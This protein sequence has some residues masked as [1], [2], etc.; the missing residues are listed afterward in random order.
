MNTKQL[1]LII[2][3]I[4]SVLFGFSQNVISFKNNNG[5]Y[6]FKD[7]FGNII[8]PPKYDYV[9]KE[10]EQKFTIVFNGE[11]KEKYPHKGKYGFVNSEGIETIKPKYDYVDREYEEEFTIVF[12]GEVKDGYPYKGKYGFVNSD[13]IE[14]IKPKYDYILFEFGLLIPVYVYRVDE[15]GADDK[16]KIGFINRN[17]KEIVGLK[18][19]YVASVNESLYIV[20]TGKTYCDGEGT[21]VPVKGKYNIINEKGV[22]IIEPLDDIIWFSNELFKTFIG[23]TYNG[24]PQKGKYGLINNNGQKIKIKDYDYIGELSDS[25]ARVF[26]GEVNEEGIPTVGKWGY[27][28]NEGNEIISLKYDKA[29]SFKNGKA[30]VKLNGED[31]YINTKGERIAE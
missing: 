18:Y 25:L 28:D 19:N 16:S 22:K 29:E 13:G 3:L 6:G 14:I 20:F 8:I 30:K 5:K 23:T 21:I 4:T 1:I 31:F 2:V 17:G 10:P 15:T 24:Y 9:N 12:N 27:I 26:I 11:V 7:S